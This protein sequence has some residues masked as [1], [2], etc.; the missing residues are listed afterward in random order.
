VI[1]ILSLGEQQRIAICRLFYH[2]PK[3]AVI[4][5]GTSALN[6]EME[7]RVFK[8]LKE[9]NIQF[10]SVGHRQ[11]LYSFHDYVLKIEGINGKW[12]YTPR[13]PP[14]MTRAPTKLQL[15]LSEEKSAPHT[16]VALEEGQSD[17]IEG[18]SSCIYWKRLCLCL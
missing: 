2:Q 1:D 5:E 11:S 16:K 12:S 13:P 7:E 3:L 18:A 15:I 6:E 8:K 10:V 17:K 4:D 9:M 14:M